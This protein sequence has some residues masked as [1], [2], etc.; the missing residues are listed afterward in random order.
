M[1]V[2]NQIME[3]RRG[4]SKLSPPALKGSNLGEAVR[5]RLLDDDPLKKSIESLEPDGVVLYGSAGS[6][7]LNPI[8]ETSSRRTTWL[9][10]FVFLVPMLLWNLGWDNYGMG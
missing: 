8:H 4:C 5:R 3:E 6:R 7:W 1:E 10:D 2:A 9:T